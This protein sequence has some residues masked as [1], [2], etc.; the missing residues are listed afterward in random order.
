LYSL[1]VDVG[2]RVQLYRPFIWNVQSIT[3]GA[4]AATAAADQG[5]ANSLVIPGESDGRDSPEHSSASGH[6]TALLDEL[7]TVYVGFVGGFSHVC[8]LY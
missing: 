8:L 2:H 5:Q 4:G 7:S 1:A 3:Y 6:S